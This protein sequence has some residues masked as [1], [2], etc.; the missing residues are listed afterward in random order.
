MAGPFLKI[1]GDSSRGDSNQ[2]QTVENT[3]TQDIDYREKSLQT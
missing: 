3:I 1:S 2:L